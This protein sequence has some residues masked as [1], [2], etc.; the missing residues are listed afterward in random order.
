MVDREGTRTELAGTR[1][2]Y[3]FPRFSPNGERF[4]VEAIGSNRGGAWLVEPPGME[5][6]RLTS[7]ANPAVWFP[8]GEHIVSMVPSED[9]TVIFRKPVDGGR[10]EVLVPADGRQ[11]L[12]TS[13]GIDGK[14]AYTEWD[15]LDRSDC[16]I[17]ATTGD[18]APEPFLNG[19]HNDLGMRF[20]PDQRHVAYVSDAGGRYEVYVTTYPD[21]DAT[22]QVSTDGGSEPVWGA[23]GREI[24]FRDGENMMVVPVN[25][26]PTFRTGTPQVLFR[27][28]YEGLLGAP[29]FANFDV[30]RDGKRLL[31]IYSPE[32]D[33]R[34]SV[35]N[36]VLGWS[37]LLE[38]AADRGR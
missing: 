2:L 15:D 38:R 13:V 37:A 30:S 19:P 20:S 18:A 12:P 14:L 7:R 24:F 31:M 25:T 9:G 16:W 22:W 1:T 33:A 35:V 11:R 21:K 27:G 10:Q 6:R 26:D 32:L 29:G 36:V 34:Q 3:R 4:V 17:V 5:F 28:A 23:D 8:D